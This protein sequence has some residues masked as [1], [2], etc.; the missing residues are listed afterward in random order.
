[1]RYFKTNK[2]KGT[3]LVYV[4]A[5]IGAASVLFAG[6][7]QFVVSHVRYNA[8]LE[9]DEQAFHVAEAGIFFY[10]WYLAHE[11]EGKTASQISDFWNNDPLGVDDNGDGDCDDPDTADGDG[12][13]TE[14]YVVD[15]EGIGQ[16]KICIVAP[17][18]YS[19]VLSIES[20]GIATSSGITKKRKIR[21]RQRK[22]SW[23]EF[24]ILANA[25]MRL[26]HGTEIFGPVHVNGGFQFDGVAHNIVSSSVET[27]YAS[28]S[29]VRA[30]R[31]GVWA[32][33]N[34]TSSGYKHLDTDDSEHFLAGKRY[35]VTVQD[36]NSLTSNFNEIRDRAIEDGTYFDNT[37]DGRMV[38][39]GQ[40]NAH[41][42]QVYEVDSYNGAFTPSV[43]TEVCSGGHWQWS[44]VFWDWIWIE[45]TCTTIEP[46]VMDIPNNGVVYVQDNLWIEGTLPE[47]Y[48]VTFAAHDPGSRTP[49][50]FLGTDDIFYANRDSDCVLGLTA[51]GNIEFLK[52]PEKGQ[53]SADRSELNI[54]AVLLSQYGR[55]GRA[56]FGDCEDTITIYGAIATN[57]RMGFGYNDGRCG[58]D[59]SGYQTRNLYFDGNLLYSPP[60]L[61]PTGGAYAV[62]LWEEIR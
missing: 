3:A 22:P 53:S 46:V 55:V 35:P 26:R 15:Y 13:G 30:T 61:F 58:G 56:D 20:E 31:P 5:M 9:P 2:K 8:S 60:P 33:A 54:D 21:A 29:D 40:P 1:M 45:G 12:D 28:D 44:W 47:D 48:K 16:F 52:N 19:T 24:A 6:T 36:F 39:L 4:L 37:G 7:I 32:A 49:R 50:I 23:S 10:R 59:G 42:M 62:D 11:L 25:D 17:E 41:Q 43:E 27:Y 14:A 57:T 18:Q 51:E 34:P 38:I